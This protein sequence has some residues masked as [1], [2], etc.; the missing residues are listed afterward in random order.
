MLGE[1]DGLGPLEVGVAGH[2]RVLVLLGLGQDGLLEVQDLVHDLPDL[3][4]EVQPQIHG[5]L[6]VAAA[7]GVEPLPRRP[8]PLR[9]QGLH[10]HVDVLVVGGELH[11]PRLDVRQDSLQPGPNGRLVL[12]GDNAAVRQHGRMGQAA[13]DVLPVQPAVELDGGVEIVH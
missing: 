6:V 2:H 8:D 4:A 10:V 1:G 7:G 11:L 3:T 12:P 9:Q 13:L 5:H